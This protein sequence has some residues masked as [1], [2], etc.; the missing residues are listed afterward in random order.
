MPGAVFFSTPLAAHWSFVDLRVYVGG[1][2]TVLHG[3]PLYDMR[4]S[5]GLAFTYPPFSAL[6]FTSAP[7][8]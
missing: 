6:S 2:R 1:G 4:F 8:P 7:C 5:R 3:G